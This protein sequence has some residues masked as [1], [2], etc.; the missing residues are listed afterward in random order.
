MDQ[1]I[2]SLAFNKQI[3]I[4]VVDATDTVSEAQKRHDTWSTSTAALGRTIIGTALLGAT[5]KGNEKVTVRIDGDGPA[6]HIVADS[7]GKGEVKGYIANPK[8][9][10]PLNEAGKIDVKGAVGTAG[11]FMVTKDLGMK[12][13][14][15][16]QVPLVSGEIGEDFTYY[17]ANSEQI[18]SAIGLSVLVNPDE[19]VKTAGGFMIQ[20][21]P[22]ADDETIGQLE[23]TL[24]NMP[25]ISQLMDEGKSPKDI[26]DKL[27]GKGNSTILETMPVTF[28]CS[29][30]KD[31]FGN[32]LASLGHGDIQEMIE[33]DHGAEAVCHFCG[34]KY[35]FTEEELKKIQEKQSD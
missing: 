21:L 3:R 14:F 1:L 19:T 27:T 31:R 6:G 30:S 15:S 13:P 5:L 26:L 23:E 12:M 24:A 22:G 11:N 20:V 34:K 7:N 9:S 35:F 8:V 2:K 17:M 4:Y 18:P 29:C 28:T 32:A 16:G 10:L 33:Q 25:L